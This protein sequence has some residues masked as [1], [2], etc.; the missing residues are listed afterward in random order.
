[1]I[2][3]LPCRA[4]DIRDQSDCF[5]AF[6]SRSK[7]PVGGTSPQSSVPRHISSKT[8]RSG[9][10]SACR[11]SLHSNN[12]FGARIFCKCVG[13]VLLK[14]RSASASSTAL[15][16][17]FLSHVALFSAITALGVDA[18][19]AIASFNAVGRLA[20]KVLGW[21]ACTAALTNSCSECGMPQANSCIPAS[22]SCSFPPLGRSGVVRSSWAYCGSV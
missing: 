7:M 11:I 3:A 20:S 1:M 5:A 6:S 4:A 19:S 2:V 10:P 18:V 16:A 13:K 21:P 22:C 12:R 8:P 9:Y 15:A 17:H 14:S